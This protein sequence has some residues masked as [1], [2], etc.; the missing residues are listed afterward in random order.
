MDGRGKYDFDFSDKV[1]LVVEDNPI[2]FK[3]MNAVLNQVKAN[4]VHASNGKVAIEACSTDT[5]FD[6][7]LMDM[8]MPEVDG[9]EATR[10][11]KELRPDL[12]VVA[13]TAH[14]YPENILACQEAGCDG[15]LTKPLQFRQM[16]E[17]MKSFFDK[18][19]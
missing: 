8:Q 17:V 5:H 6:L 10:K 1:V 4:V 13:T 9:L 15:F 7:V 18:Q 12:P 11:I 3:L 14:T 19:A 2:A 16:F